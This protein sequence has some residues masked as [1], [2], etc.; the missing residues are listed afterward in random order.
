M[1]FQKATVQIYFLEVPLK[2][3]KEFLTDWEQLATSLK[4]N[5]DLISIHLHKEFGK[6]PRWFIYASWKSSK[7]RHQATAREKINSLLSDWVI[8]EMPTLY[9]LIRK[10]DNP[11]KNSF[12]LSTNLLFFI[13]W[14]AA[15]IAVGI[16]LALR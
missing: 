9:E 6:S 2:Q 1:K 12:T 5:P 10:D 11:K 16:I 15:I 8:Q 7:D 14:I 3:T 13:I 4:K